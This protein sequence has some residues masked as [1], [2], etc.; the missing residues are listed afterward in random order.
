MAARLTFTEENYPAM[1]T[2]ILEMVEGLNGRLEAFYYALGEIDATATVDVPDD[3]SLAAA[4]LRVNAAGIGRATATALLT[5]E[6]HRQG[7]QE[8]GHVSSAWRIGGSHRRARSC[9][10]TRCTILTA[11]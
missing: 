7:H 6:R 10:Y 2:A 11:A 4:I 9:G 5:P 3:V 1:R 8:T